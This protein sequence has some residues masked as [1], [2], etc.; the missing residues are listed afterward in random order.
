[1]KKT[2]S[3]ILSICVI[4]GCFVSA[5]TVS[6]VEAKTTMQENAQDG[7]EKVSARNSYY[8]YLLD[9]ADAQLV[10]D[11]TIELDLSKAKLEGAKLEKYNGEQ[12]VVIDQLGVVSITFNVEKPGFYMLNSRYAAV[13]GKPINMELCVYIDGKIPYTE[14]TAVSIPRIWEDEIETDKNGNFPKVDDNGNQ[15]IPNAKQVIEYR[16]YIFHDNGYM[17]DADMLFYFDKGKHTL[18]LESTREA[19][20]FSKLWFGCTGQVGD[21]N[22]YLEK[23]AQAKVYDG[24]VLQF[25]AEKSTQRSEQA[26]TM[27]ADL[28]N[29]S[30]TPADPSQ[31]RLNSIGGESWKN[32]GQWVS[33][34]VDVPESANYVLTF[35]Y[36]QDY[37]N[38]FKVYREILI[39]GEVPYQELNCVAFDPNTSWDNMTVSDSEGKP[40][41]IYLEKGKHTIT[42]NA[43]LGPV[44]DSLQVLTN[45]VSDLNQIYR[46]IISIT[47]V[48]P[49]PNRDYDIDRV[50]PD[51]MDNFQSVYD[52][53]IEVGKEI[54]QYN[55]VKG[56]LS[57]FID[58]STAQIEKF[59]KDP[60]KIV[61]GLTNFKTNIASLA[62]MMSQMKSQALLLDEFYLSGESEDVPK[63]K[64]GFFDSAWFTIK[65]FFL[66]FVADY[67][68]LGVDYNNTDLVFD[69]DK[70][71]EVWMVSGR[72]QMNV[73]K[74]IIDDDFVS[75]HNIPVNL[76]LIDAATALTKAILAGT[77]PD[78]A[79]WLGD[80][81]PVSYSMRGAL[82]NLDQ[83][84]AE[85][86][87]DEK[88]NKRYTYTFDEVY[89]WFYPSSFV[90]LRY[91]D[92]KTY[93][94]PESQKFKMM[95]IREDIMQELGLDVPK[96]WD[97]VYQIV[98]IIQRNNMMIGIPS[99]DMNM[100]TTLLLQNGC[101]LYVDDYSA[102]DL[103]TPEAINAFT[104]WT[105]FNTKYSLPLSYD[106]L[107]RFRSGEMPILLNDY[108]FYNNLEI[109]APEIK[110]LWSMYP[111]P[112]T[113][114]KDGS[115]NTAQMT[116]GNT[117]IMVEGCD[118]KEAVWEFM[119]WW[120]S[121][122]VQGEF[123]QK[124]EARLGAG[125]RYDTANKE[126]FEQ[127]PWSVKEQSMIKEAWAQVENIAKVPGNYYV[128]RMVNNAFRSVVYD[129]T[130]TREALIKYSKEMNK[131][132]QR[133]R[134]EYKIDRF[135][136]NK[137]N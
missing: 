36:R 39:D 19:I 76:S 99:Q 97:E 47:G 80:G 136:D 25:A 84:D 126:A 108:V 93:G 104:Q 29:A 61:D 122:D 57:S 56:G 16:D 21:Y 110:G 129:G 6:A 82:E 13:Q 123:G 89:D 49:D 96:T 127:I 117:C 27:Y 121:G 52:R 11:T 18:T 72:D 59:L 33:W 109:G 54:Q 43:T 22:Q 79:I 58:V 62:D 102:V 4:I 73:L 67:N 131:E 116:Y 88:G 118:N 20:A 103:N 64:V 46:D 71:V 30:T 9:Y 15:L 86:Q 105:E 133:K 124:I 90:S 114:Q 98:T 41:Y 95:F 37:V 75:N 51:L 130:N 53:L 119:S 91:L 28:S 70:P 40:Y 112:G 92:G 65:G 128:N 137:N 12:A 50:I 24:E 78:C 23:H 87:Y 74:T 68:A 77:G 38:G 44:A 7:L 113:V 5:F 17:T 134:E 1:M 2:L 34:E 45:A 132:I 48:T 14:A 83:F 125:G 3:I 111:I 120:V 63:A 106:P 35:K 10:E 66:S 135:F 81:E 100:F 85:H 60:L 115:I 32:P 55:G 69:I 94:L 26:L 8:Y 101:D 31:V 42:L 107:N